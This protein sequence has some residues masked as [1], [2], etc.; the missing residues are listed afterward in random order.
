[1]ILWYFQ[2]PPDTNERPHHAPSARG[3]ESATGSQS[4]FDAIKQVRGDG[5]KFWSARDLMEVMGYAQWRNFHRT[6]LRTS[7][8][9]ATH[10]VDVEAHAILSTRAIAIGSGAV[11]NVVDY[12]ISMFYLT[13]LAMFCG[14]DSTH[15]IVTAR[16]TLAA[17]VS[18]AHDA[19]ASL[20]A[21]PNIDARGYVYVVEG[22]NGY[23]KVGRSVRPETRIYLSSSRIL[24]VHR[25]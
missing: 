13:V 21:P 12:D 6:I 1:M 4:P 17:E 2:T 25:S 3:T 24:E 15:Q 7:K 20:Q 11:R 14:G 19:L 18:G 16:L 22:S 23:I 9:L 8:V 5:T 10:G